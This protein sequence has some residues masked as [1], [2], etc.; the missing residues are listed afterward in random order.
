MLELPQTAS[1]CGT[2]H[3]S[4]EQLLAERC[5]GLSPL[6]CGCG[7]RCGGG[8]GGGFSLKGGGGAGWLGGGGR[9]NGGGG[10]GG[11]G[12]G[13][14]HAKGTVPVMLALKSLPLHSPH[15]TQPL[16]SSHHFL[17]PHSEWVSHAS[18]ARLASSTSS[19]TVVCIGVDSSQVGAVASARGMTTGRRASASQFA[20]VCC[21]NAARTCG[22]AAFTFQTSHS[23]MF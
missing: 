15:A 10:R 23:N 8:G 4:S 22:W 1:P 16:V 21:A 11:R 18:P 2:F 7:R 6:V 14:A 9:G 19:A 17:R 20:C 13:T 5:C 3:L 12:G